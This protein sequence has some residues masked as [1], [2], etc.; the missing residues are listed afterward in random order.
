MLAGGS[1]IVPF[2]IVT[3]DHGSGFPNA[4]S[5]A[6]RVLLATTKPLPAE[7]TY[8]PGAGEPGTYATSL[9]FTL[10]YSGEDN[11]LETFDNVKASE[12]RVGDRDPH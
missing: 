7:S 2:H 1:A 3:A 4:L 6:E 10:P 8:T 5:G 9:S 12:L 11:R